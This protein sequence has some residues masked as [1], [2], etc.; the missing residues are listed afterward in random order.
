MGYQ[1]ILAA[2]V[3]IGATWSS[4][5]CSYNARLWAEQ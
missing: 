5:S 3:S 1:V 4:V 2:L